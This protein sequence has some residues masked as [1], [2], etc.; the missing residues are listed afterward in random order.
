M[1]HLLACDPGTT[2]SAFIRLVDGKINEKHYL[3]NSSAVEWLKTFHG[4]FVFEMVA[5]YGMAVGRETF[6][7]VLWCGRFAEASRTVPLK[8]PNTMPSSVRKVYRKDIKMHLCQSMRAKDA[9]IRQALIDKLG[10]VGTKRN[11]GPL[12]GISSHLW[13]ALAVAIYAQECPDGGERL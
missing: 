9:N 12:Y 2:M 3:P 10:P 11:P 1:T 4:E 13:S 6:E 7:T 8:Y 5:S